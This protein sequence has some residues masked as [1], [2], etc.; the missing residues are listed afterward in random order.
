MI[1]FYAS[2]APYGFLNN[3]APARF[4]IFNEWWNNVEQA[5][6]SQKTDVKEEIDLIRNAETANQA[7]EL[8]QKVTIRS[9]WEYIKRDVMKQCV[10]Q[11]FLQHPNLRIRLM[12]TGNEKIEEDSP[13]DWFWGVGS[14]GTGQNHMGKILVE[15]REMLKGE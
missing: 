5:Y 3:Y 6:Q 14:D 11:K 10:L 13:I 15:V 12:N 1:K 4:F 7:R 2:K 8:G 9:N